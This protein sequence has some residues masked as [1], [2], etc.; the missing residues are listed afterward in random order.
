M[1]I[2]DWFAEFRRLHDLARKKELKPIE[3]TAYLSAREQL[4]RS[5]CVAQGLSLEGES[6]RKTFRVAQAMQIELSL[7]S[8]QLKSVTM[9]ISSGGFSV[10]MKQP[11]DSNEAVGF[12]L[13]LPG[14]AEPL[15]GR[16]KVVAVNKQGGNA[17]VSFSFEK[18]AEPD[19]ERLEML[20]FDCALARMP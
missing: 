19:I 6:A 8:G 20:L 16:G 5:F 18:L 17:R 3:R 1:D 10:L 4:A 14:G 2:R 7:A 13:K 9:D 12:T 15:V 11:P